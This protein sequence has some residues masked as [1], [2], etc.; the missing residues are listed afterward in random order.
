MIRQS[1]PFIIAEDCA[2]LATVSAA[3]QGLQAEK[4]IRGSVRVAFL[5]EVDKELRELLELQHQHHSHVPLILADIFDSAPN[6]AQ[7]QRVHLYACGF[8]CQPE[9]TM[10]KEMRGRDARAL[11]VQAML[12][13]I[14]FGR[15][16]SCL[17]EYVSGFTRTR[18]FKQLCRSLEDFGY[19]V[20]TRVLNTR[21]ITSIPHCRTRL[22][23]VAFLACVARNPGQFEW[24]SESPPQTL[25]SAILD[26][27]LPMGPAPVTKTAKRNLDHAFAYLTSGVG[28][29]NLE[30]FHSIVDLQASN[31]RE[32]CRVE[33]S[34]CI[35]KA[36]AS[37]KAF[38]I[39]RNR[40]VTQTREVSLKEYSRMQGWSDDMYEFRCR[41]L[42]DTLH[43]SALG[44][45]MTLG[46]VQRVV[47]RML[48]HITW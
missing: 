3:V 7:L 35:T 29:V 17:L 2:G 22:Y 20:H 45:G 4:V 21:D 19:V 13:Y 16:L 11:P 5:S 42:R 6:G 37:A 34:P 31:G 8:P 38:H 12:S 36:R 43:A 23:I 25:T 33:Y 41:R 27:S 10:G 47:A 15:P 9:S 24:P 46:V 44:N 39:I 1:D 28:A 30:P 14:K 32:Q 40:D 18:R 26:L 48:P